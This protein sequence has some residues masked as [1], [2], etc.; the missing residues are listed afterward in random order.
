[1]PG[2]WRIRDRAT[3]AA[4]RAA[5]RRGRSGP[6]AVT[7]LPRRCGD[8]DGARVAYAVGRRAGGAVTRNRIRRRLRAAVAA[9]PAQ[10]PPGAYLVSAGGEAATCPFEELVDHLG[11][12]L[13]EAAR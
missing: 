10:P 6:V 2:V 13:R 11:R 1:V 9:L 8:P 12:A 4:L 5:G 3:F 7:F